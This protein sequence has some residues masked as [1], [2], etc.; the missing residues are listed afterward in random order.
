[1]AAGKAFQLA[2]RAQLLDK[3]AA[4][5]GQAVSGLAADA[6]AFALEARVAARKSMAE[7]IGH[8]KGFL[9]EYR[10]DVPPFFNETFFLTESEKR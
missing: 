3:Q 6:E 4:D 2:L 9:I 10:S 7:L 8:G 5:K 1:M